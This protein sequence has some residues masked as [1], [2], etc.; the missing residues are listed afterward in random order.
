MSMREQ[1]EATFPVPAGVKWSDEH[2]SYGWIKKSAFQKVINYRALW[3]GWQ[4]SREALIVRLPQRWSIDAF[5]GGW[6]ADADGANLD[7]TETVKAIEVAGLS[8]SP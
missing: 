1:F 3:R 7:Y 4:A 5:E 2:Q 8:V 6:V